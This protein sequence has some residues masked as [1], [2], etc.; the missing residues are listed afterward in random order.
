MKPFI[1]PHVHS[2]VPVLT[3]DNAESLPADS[4]VRF[5]GMII[6]MFNP[7]FFVGTYQLPDGTWEPAALFTDT[8]PDNMDAA[9]NTRIMERRPLLLTPVP[10][11]QPWATAAWTGHPMQPETPRYSDRPKRIREAS[12]EAHTAA[13]KHHTAS[14][15]NAQAHKAARVA[16]SDVVDAPFKEIDAIP[17]KLQQDQDQFKRQQPQQEQVPDE[18]QQEE[19]SSYQPGDCIVQVYEDADKFRLHDVVE[20]LGVLSV[21]PGFAALHLQQQEQQQQRRRAEAAGGDAIQAAADAGGAGRGGAAMADDVMDVDGGWWQHEEAAALPPT[22]QVVNR[23]AG[24]APGLVPLSLTHVPGRGDAG[25]ASQLVPGLAAVLSCLLPRVAL[26]PLTLTVLNASRWY[27][28]QS[29]ETS[30]LLRGRLQLPE[31]TLLLL[32]ETEMAAG[33]L[34]DTGVKNLQAVQQVLTHQKLPCG[35]QVYTQDLPVNLPAVVLSTGRS[36]LRDSLAV[37]LPLQPQ[38]VMTVKPGQTSSNAG[39]G[40][41]LPP[42]ADWAG[43]DVAGPE[44][45]AAAAAAAEPELHMMRQYLEAARG[46]QCSMDQ[47]AAEQC[48]ARFRAQQRVEP[49]LGYGDLD[50]MVTVTPIAEEVITEFD[51]WPTNEIVNVN[52]LRTCAQFTVYVPTSLPLQLVAPTGVGNRITPAELPYWK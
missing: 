15:P 2:Q 45:I 1:T 41:A 38:P 40:I 50:I 28:Q 7:E 51:P 47:T 11:E 16:G 8:T 17:S 42:A 31:G 24:G 6:D 33:Q 43:A 30:R 14:E 52:L 13:T 4:L 25:R 39:Q 48:V 37:Q 27:P 23:D 5:R 22:S 49:G 3:F 19:H 34:G 36:I 9:I 18:L 35:C 21:V 10:H 29:A 12:L 46:L 44:V 32:D 26:L 20:V